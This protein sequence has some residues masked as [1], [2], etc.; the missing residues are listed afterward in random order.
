MLY[1]IHKIIA[2]KLFLVSIATAGILL[3]SCNGT[4]GTTITSD[5][6]KSKVTIDPSAIAQSG[7]E[8]QKK[9]DELKKLPPLTMDQLKALLPD[10]LGGIKRSSFSANAAMGFSVGEA[11]YKKD[12]STSLKLDVYDCAG[13]AGSSFYGLS[14]WTKMSMQSENDQG[15]TKTIDFMGQKAVETY[16]KGGE[17]YTETFVAND[18]LLISVQGSHTGLD[19]IKQAA[20]SLNLKVN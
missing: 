14:Y 7:D 12:D 10:E 9:I 11:E 15:Y 17:T 18:R 6:G 5:D 2:M 20:Q 1:L 16:E 13:E 3:T 4:P 8:M 19:A